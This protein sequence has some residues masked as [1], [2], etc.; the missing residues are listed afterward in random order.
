MVH[1]EIKGD[2]LILTID[3]STTAR[4]N[5]EASKSGKSRVLATT[6]GFTRYGDMAVSLNVTIDKATLGVAK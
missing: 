1:G 2:K 5:A 4:Q 3:C 6:H